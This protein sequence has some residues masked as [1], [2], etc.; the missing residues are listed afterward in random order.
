MRPVVLFFLLVAASARIT[1]QTTEYFIAR[2]PAGW[3][4]PHVVQPGQTIFSLSRLFAVPPAALADANNLTYADGLRTGDTVTIPLGAYNRRYSPPTGAHSQCPSLRY[5][6]A[7]GETLYALAREVGVTQK[8]LMEWNHLDTPGLH[9][10]YLLT[11]GWL[12]CTSEADEG[13]L[14]D[15]RPATEYTDAGPPDTVGGETPVATVPGDPL[16]AAW[17]LA[18][19]DGRSATTERGTAAFFPVGSGARGSAL[20]AFHN[21]AARGSVLR[22]LNIGT[23]RVAYVKVLGPLPSTKTYAGAMVGLS[24]AARGALGVRGDARMWCEVSYAGY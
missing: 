22:I 8:T 23:G 15:T 1:A 20:Y 12:R 18:T 13:T 4:I 5:R 3:A 14:P 7:R 16:E 6:V 9:A 11:L 21:S 10:D 24:A 2:T 19:D 17:L